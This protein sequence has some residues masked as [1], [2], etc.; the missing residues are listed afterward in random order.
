MCPRC[1]RKIATKGALVPLEEER[2]NTRAINSSGYGGPFRRAHPRESCSIYR[3]RVHAENC[4]QTT[5]LL[6]KLLDILFLKWRTV[7]ETL[8]TRKHRNPQKRNLSISIEMRLA[9]ARSLSFV[10]RCITLS[11]A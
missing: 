2:K 6:R 11:A 8:W 9:A 10:Y 3:K 5:G 1:V 4:R 7:G